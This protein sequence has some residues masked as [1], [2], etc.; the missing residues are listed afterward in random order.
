MNV[1]TMTVGQTEEEKTIKG[2]K[3]QN[4]VLLKRLDALEKELDT[5]N[6]N[7]ERLTREAYL[8]GRIE[9]L[10]FSIKC[11]GVNGDMVK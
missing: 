11:N 4:E 3:E 7:M 10:E 5:I 9:G 1:P 6:A 2:L 8:K